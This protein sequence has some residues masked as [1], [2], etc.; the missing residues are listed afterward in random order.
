M[1]FCSF[2]KNYFN[3]NDSTHW[4]SNGKQKPRCKLQLINYNSKNA[5]KR[6]EYNQNYYANNKNSILIKTNASYKEN[7]LKISNLRLRRRQQD[8]LLRI[9]DTYSAAAR[10]AFAQKGFGKDTKSAYLLGC[11]FEELKT[12]LESKFDQTMSW[13]NYGIIWEID[14][15]CPI[16]QAKVY[17]EVVKLCCY[18]NLR[19]L[20]ITLNRRKNRR[21]T[22]EAEIMCNLLLNRDWK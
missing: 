14:H 17:D 9:K 22:N 8:P 10:R 15:I 12:H 1:R 4:T 20:P 3:E 11:S 2:C 5:K 16:H 21:K 13:E 7:K 18:L 19:P 6:H